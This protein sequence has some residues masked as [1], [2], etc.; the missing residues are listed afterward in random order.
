VTASA[1]VTRSAG[2][3]PLARLGAFFFRYRDAVFPG[4][5]GVMVLATDPQRLLGSDRLDAFADSV[6]IL[7]SALGQA[8]RIAV[9]GYAYIIRGG[10]KRKVY[11]ED[12]VTGGLFGI[13][14][15][16]LYLGNLLVILGLLLIWNSPWAYAVCV[17][18]FLLGYRAIVAAEEGYLRA[19]FGAAYDQYCREV[20]RWLPAWGRLAS[21]VQGI[22]FHWHRVVLKEYGTIA[23]W[24]GTTLT[25]IVLETI[26]FSTV[27]GHPVR[28]AVCVLLIAIV[29][30][31]WAITRWLK[32]THRLQR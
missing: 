12:L 19:R 9:V 7:L 30:A 2:P 31:A 32:V 28:L 14:R 11:A 6:G 24:L 26:S 8:L 15:N 25:L 13:C 23:A 17:P 4:V 10:R 18:F 3:T 20:R 22:G 21:S 29:V 5:F 16:P 27:A 1:G